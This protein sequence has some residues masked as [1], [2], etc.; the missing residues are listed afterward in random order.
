MT[1]STTETELVAAALRSLGD[2]AI[3][4]LRDDSERARIAELRYPTIRDG[5]LRAHRWPCALGS[6]E[7]A[8]MVTPPVWG[9][10]QQF[11]L[12]ADCL[13]VL[14]TDQ[15]SIPWVVEGRRLLTSRTVVRIRYIRRV[16]DVSQYDALVLEAL[17]TRLAAELAIA[18]TGSRT[19][20]EAHFARYER[21]LAEA[22][23]I[24]GQE[25]MPHELE[26]TQLISVRG[27]GPSEW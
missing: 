14:E 19:L 11:P 26:S 20:A 2:E 21:K 13:R 17:I 9:A 16:T 4:T 15:E 10:T 27:I 24:A 18:I 6:A 5:V 7:L 23:A 25:G 22:R 1:P 8:P 3:S 12:P